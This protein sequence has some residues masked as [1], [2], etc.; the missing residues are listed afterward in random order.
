MNSC[1][2][3]LLHHAPK[4]GIHA[5]ENYLA[6]YQNKQLNQIVIPGSHDAGIYGLDKENV[7]TQELDIG[8]QAMAGVRFFD[9]RIATAKSGWG[10]SATYEQKSY[11]LDGSLVN[12]SSHSV[13]KHLP[14][15]NKDVKSHQNIS[16]AGGWGG[17]TLGQMLTQAKGFVD[18]HPTEFLIMKF[19]KCFNLQNVLDKCLEVLK[20]SQF[21][22]DWTCN[23]NTQPVSTLA[24]HVITLFDE[25][26]L[27]SLKLDYSS[28]RYFGCFTFKEIYDKKSNT[29]RAL[30]TKL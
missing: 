10:N 7:K 8:G 30:R 21:Q 9:M 25:K 19:S 29:P 26:A 2:F 5:R 18:T 23:L 12:N 22:T 17:D 16:H 13:R 11:H 14:G 15:G 6:A 27:A 1:R 20:G 4:R 24:G 28:G 3:A